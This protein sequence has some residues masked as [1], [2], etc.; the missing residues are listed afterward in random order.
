[1]G[2]LVVAAVFFQTA[3]SSSMLQSIM[4]A[5]KALGLDGF[6]Q[7]GLFFMFLFWVM[8]KLGLID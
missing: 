8:T 6:I 3:P 4:A 2:L 7:T 1:M 5:I